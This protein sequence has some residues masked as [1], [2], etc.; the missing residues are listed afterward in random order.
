MEKKDHTGVQEKSGIFLENDLWTTP[1]PPP[2]QFCTWILQKVSQL[3]LTR[4]RS[5][6]PP[7]LS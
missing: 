7:S 3:N 6:R 5:A 4:G 1:D 2:Y